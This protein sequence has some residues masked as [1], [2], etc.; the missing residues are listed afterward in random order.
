VDYGPVCGVYQGLVTTLIGYFIPIF[1]A[2]EKI[3]QK[4]YVFVFSLKK[5]TKKLKNHLGMCKERTDLNLERPRQNI[6]SHDPLP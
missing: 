5:G 6:P 3:L 2:C 4:T 1:V